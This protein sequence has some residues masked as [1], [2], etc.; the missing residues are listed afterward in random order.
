VTDSKPSKSARKRAQQDLQ[1]LG[2]ELAALGED[3]LAALDLDERLLEAIRAAAGIRSRS[4]LRR[5][6]QLI[7]K[8]MRNVDPGPIRE[9][10]A[11]L[12]ARE[13]IDKRR[14]AAAERWRERLVSGGADAITAFEAEVGLEDDELRLSLAEFGAAPDERRRK[15]ARRKIFRRVHAILGRIPQ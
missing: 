6:R 4:A 3:E 15:A 1:S 9:R 14:F 5:Q 7:G 11:L 13:N 12:R 8:L 10:L 2:E